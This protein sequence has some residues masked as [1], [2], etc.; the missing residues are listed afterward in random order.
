MI[1]SPT[2]ETLKAIHCTA[3]AN[4]LENQLNDPEPYSQLGFEERLAMIVD[5][6]WNKRRKNKLQRLV[7]K[8]NFSQ[9]TACKE[10]FRIFLFEIFGID[11]KTSQKPILGL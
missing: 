6:E 10:I 8:A 11:Q 5:A 7:R 1:N 2:I 4:E 9:P 3:M